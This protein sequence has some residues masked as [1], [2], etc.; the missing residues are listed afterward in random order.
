MPIIQYT[1]TR[2]RKHCNLQTLGVIK[3][4]CSVFHTVVRLVEH[5]TWAVNHVFGDSFKIFAITDTGKLRGD[6]AV[7]D[8]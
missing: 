5:T 6:N 4:T 3:A 7:N 8:F 1:Q 2:T